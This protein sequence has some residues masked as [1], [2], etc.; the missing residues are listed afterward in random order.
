MQTILLLGAGL[1]SSSLIRYLLSHADENHW[2]LRIG[3]LNPE[4]ARGKVQGHPCAEVFRF[5][6]T[7]NDERAAAIGQAD[8]VISMLPARFHHLVA[9]SCIHLRTT[10]VTASYVS[11]QLK[12]MADEAA[13]KGVLL[14]NEMGVD[15][16]IDHMS[17]MRVIHRLKEA[18][19]TIVAF[20]SNTGGLIA[21][22][23]DNNPWNYK[24]TWNP[25]N[26]VVAGKDGARFLDHGKLK[27]IPYH[28]LFERTER[29]NIGRLGEFEA[30]PNRD[31]LTYQKAY[32]LENVETMFRGTIRRH[33]Y[34]KAWNL[35]VQLGTTD[36]TYV[37]GNSEELSCI[38]FTNTFLAYDPLKDVEDKVANYLGVDKE[39]AMM[40]KLRWLGLFSDRKMGVANA[41]PA[42][43]L[44]HVLEQKWQMDPDDKDMIVMQHQFVSR[45]EDKF[46][47]TLSTLI[48]EGEDEI[49]TA[50][51]LTVG[52]PVAIATKLILTGKIK[53]EGVH[54]PT[55]PEIYTPILD[56]LHEFGIRFEEETFEIAAY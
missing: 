31:S 45:K 46:K 4:M 38:D 47:K 13:Q 44:Q 34:C 27:Y 40:Y 28:K 35:L 33:G 14:L 17:A 51:S 55:I 43:Y 50:M 22:K 42:K 39:S 21:P 6:V 9:E 29:L 11:E 48:I 3:E 10:M 16:G 37:L 56:E 19:E 24:F 49:H 26:V 7:N 8:I 32:G 2:K 20:E 23:Y 18:G 41:T 25:R 52:L 53:A 12:T 36:D 15:P 54:I 30:Y 5:N 1:S